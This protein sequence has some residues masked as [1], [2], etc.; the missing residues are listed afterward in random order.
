MTDGT[1]RLKQM[2]N[3]EIVELLL[4]NCYYCYFQVI[5]L[6]ELRNIQN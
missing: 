6:I 2:K 3:H 4:F 1:E 5:C